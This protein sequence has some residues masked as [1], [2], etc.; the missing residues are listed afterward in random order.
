[1]ARTKIAATSEVKF[2]LR[3]YLLEQYPGG[4]S[5]LARKF[6]MTRQAVDAWEQKNVVPPRNVL[7]VAKELG[8]SPHR[9]APDLYPRGLHVK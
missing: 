8:M 1:M 6:G 7:K 5:A 9:I 3:E 2:N 4:A